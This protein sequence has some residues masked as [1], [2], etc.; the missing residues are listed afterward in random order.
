MQ[1]ID[2]K[3]FSVVEGLLVLVIVG[4]IGGVGWFVLQ[5]KSKTNSTTNRTDSST[6]PQEQAT[7]KSTI[8]KS[9]SVKERSLQPSAK[10]SVWALYEDKTNSASLH[11]PD[12]WQVATYKSFPGGFIAWCGLGTGWNNPE[13]ITYKQG[14]KATITDQAHPTE[15]FSYLAF[16][17]QDGVKDFPE[18]SDSEKVLEKL[19][20]KSVTIYKTESDYQPYNEED[21]TPKGTKY[22]NYY[23]KKGDKFFLLH[24]GLKPGEANQ[25]E[26]VEDML[27]TLQ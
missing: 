5:A 7:A 6:K 11:I 20:T 12:G 23:I 24:Y 1:K 16:T 21:K 27:A 26:L 13:C 25:S 10:T 2:T 4:I 14:V 9:S 19:T 3:G 8:D 22:Y 17:F 15:G 18:Q